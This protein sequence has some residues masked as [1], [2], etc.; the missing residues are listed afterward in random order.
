MLLLAFCLG[1]TRVALTRACRRR[2]LLTSNFDEKK[3][4]NFQMKKI[5]C[6]Y[7][8]RILKVVG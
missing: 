6:F 8:A 1:A 7:D 3:A 2:K 4:R 5:R